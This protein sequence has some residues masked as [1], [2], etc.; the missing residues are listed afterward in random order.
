M[1]APTAP[2]N[3]HAVSSASSIWTLSNPTPVAPFYASLAGVGPGADLMPPDAHS[4]VAPKLVVR[5]GFGL[6]ECGSTAADLGDDLFG[7]A[8]PD[9]G[10]RVVLPAPRAPH[11]GLDPLPEAAEGN[12]GY[13]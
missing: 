6:G 13:S 2:P 9:E 4:T 11:A 10:L 5:R 3:S 12:A 1:P 7:G 8:V